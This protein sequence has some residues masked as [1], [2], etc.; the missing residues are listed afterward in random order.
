MCGGDT[1]REIVAARQ[2]AAAGRFPDVPRS[3]GAALRQRRVTRLKPGS[4]YGRRQPK[5]SKRCP[6]N[7]VFASTAVLAAAMSSI[8]FAD[9]GDGPTTLAVYGDAPYGCKAP[10]AAA[11]PDECPVGSPY[12]P[13]TPNGPNPGDP[14]QID[15]T[16][17]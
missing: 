4:V 8:A 16:P 7:K 2:W 1:Y 13:D 14:R 3:P 9:R 17:A 6:V 5:V 12:T 15:A 11:A 10:S